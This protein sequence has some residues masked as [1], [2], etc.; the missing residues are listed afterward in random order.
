MACFR[1][2]R[3]KFSFPRYLK[4]CKYEVQESWEV[5]KFKDYLYSI[6]NMWHICH[7]FSILNTWQTLLINHCFLRQL[8][9]PSQ[10]STTIAIYHKQLR[11]QNHQE[12]IEPPYFIG[13]ETWNIL[14]SLQQKIVFLIDLLSIHK[15]LHF[16]RILRWF[17][18]ALKFEK[19]WFRALDWSCHRWEQIQREAVW[20]PYAGP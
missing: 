17:E 15:R 19:N 6:F 12:L 11:E 20:Q 18:S 10:D 2:S 1:Y 9:T 16:K 13:K 3:K 14:Y 4:Y 7:V 5:R 8:Q